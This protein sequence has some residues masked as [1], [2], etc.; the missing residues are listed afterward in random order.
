MSQ[1]RKAVEQILENAESPKSRTQTID[2][3]DSN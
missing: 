3:F 2:F 1:E